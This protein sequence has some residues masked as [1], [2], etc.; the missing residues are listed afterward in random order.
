MFCPCIDVF[1]L[2]S[3][4]IILFGLTVFLIHNCKATCINQITFTKWNLNIYRSTYYSVLKSGF[5]VLQRLLS[6]PSNMAPSPPFLFMLTIALR[7]WP[8]SCKSG[9]TPRVCV[10]S[11]HSL[12]L[13]GPTATFISGVGFSHRKYET[14]KI[15]T[16][17]NLS[18]SIVRHL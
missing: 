7:I 4:D 12:W 5:I 9:I 2:D 3:W 6:P 18:C 13:M 10:A 17:N 11:L 16:D 1:K 14:N 8:D 15:K